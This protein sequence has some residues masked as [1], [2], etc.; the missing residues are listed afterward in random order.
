MTQI[1][2]RTTTVPIFVGKE[3]QQRDK[4]P[5]QVPLTCP[6]FKHTATVCSGLDASTMK[7]SS[8]IHLSYTNTTFNK[9]LKVKATHSY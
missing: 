2:A 1:L 6:S 3:T 7:S 8:L 5:N 4:L 9:E